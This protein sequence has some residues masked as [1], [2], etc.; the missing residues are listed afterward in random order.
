MKILK[1]LFIG[2]LSVVFATACKKG[3]DPIS[4]VDPGPD[5]AAPV[6][7]ISY[8][9][10]GTKIRVDEA[11]TSI[12][13]KF[14]AADDIEVK[15][16]S[17]MLD[18]TEIQS[19]TSFKDYRR[20]SGAFQYD[21]VEN[22]DH[23]LSVVATDLAGKITTQ[24]VNFKKIPAY[25]PLPGEV[26]YLPFD[27]DN[28]ELV[29]K[30]FVTVVGIP[31]FTTGKVEQAYAGATDAYITYPTTAS[32]FL[33]SE[34]SIAFWYKLNGTPL[35]GGIFA[36]ARPYTVYNDTT[37]YKGFR[38]L[39][40][41]SG[42]KQNLGINLGTG[43]AEVWVNP[44]LTIAP[45]DTWMHIAVTASSTKATVY[46]DGVV[47]KTAV[48]KGSIDWTDCSMLSLASGKP[49]FAYW[50][51]FSDLSLYDEVHIFNKAI[52]QEEVTALF[53]VKK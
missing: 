25:V 30:K 40:E 35:R 9:V 50:D 49:N 33:G 27:G 22:G 37:R 42:L 26:F 52:T 19:F 16:I 34:F 41:N 23:V 20:Y 12:V 28:F 18:G 43:K 31:S 8:P 2:L 48:L 17:L 11:V 14:V 47:V 36:I 29:G 3:I 24:T 45:S 13:I 6:V 10:E 53:S 5:T 44:F 46:V 15:S 39:R 38:F 1:Y 32:G 7:S 51:H 4:Y 21:N